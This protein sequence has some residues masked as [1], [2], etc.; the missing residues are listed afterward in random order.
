[1][2]KSY[3]QPSGRIVIAGK[4]IGYGG[5]AFLARIPGFEDSGGVLLR[6]I[7]GQGASASEH[8]DERLSGG[9]NRLQ[10]FLL[11]PGKVEVQTIASE[12]ARIT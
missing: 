7:H 8:H 4:D 10:K 11:R 12:K 1:M 9:S 6:P 3:R 2:I 5:A